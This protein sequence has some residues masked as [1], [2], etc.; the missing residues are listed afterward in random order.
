MIKTRIQQGL[1]GNLGMVAYSKQILQ[2]EGSKAFFLGWQQ[3]SYIIG[4]LYGL[5]S[6]AFEVQKR[7]LSTYSD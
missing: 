4:T 6:L 2:Q 7:W 3:R 5:V 1:N